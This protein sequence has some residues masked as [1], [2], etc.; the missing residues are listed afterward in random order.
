[1][2]GLQGINITWMRGKGTL[3]TEKIKSDDDI[4]N[5]EN[6]IYTIMSLGNFLPNSYGTLLVFRSEPRYVGFQ[7]FVDNTTPQLWVRRFWDIWS[8]WRQVQTM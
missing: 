8:S 4:K 5:L 1:M 7:I 3:T 6:G 2:G